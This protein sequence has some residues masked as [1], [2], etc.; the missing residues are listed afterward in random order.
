MAHFHL[1]LNTSKTQF[2]PLTKNQFLFLPSLFL[3]KVKS[4]FSIPDLSSPFAP[5]GIV[6]PSSNLCHCPD[7]LCSNLPAHD[8]HTHLP[9]SEPVPGPQACQTGICSFGLISYRNF[10]PLSLLCEV[11]TEIF[12]KAT[13]IPSEITFLSRALKSF[14]LTCHQSVFSNKCSMA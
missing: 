13:V 5:T 7:V 14:P 9:A 2:L 11:K 12:G 6:T 1:K 3:F 4:F 8:C 10:I